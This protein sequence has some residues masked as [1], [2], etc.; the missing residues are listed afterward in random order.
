MGDEVRYIDNVNWLKEPFNKVK[1][2]TQ[3]D[4]P[5]AWFIPDIAKQ[6]K[7]AH[8][9][10]ADLGWNEKELKSGKKR[11]IVVFKWLNLF[12]FY[13][14]LIILGSISAGYFWPKSFRKRVLSLGIEDAYDQM[15]TATKKDEDIKSVEKGK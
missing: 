10:Q 4:N 15:D 3:Y 1:S 11:F 14:V 12:V 5:D 8:S 7:A 13:C 6:I 2:K 9:L